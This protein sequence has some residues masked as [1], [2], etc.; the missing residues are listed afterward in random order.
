M[1]RIGKV[2][3]QSARSYECVLC[4]PN[5]EPLLAMHDYHIKCDRCG[6]FYV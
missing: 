3:R 5:P 1:Q 6:E 4:L 2:D